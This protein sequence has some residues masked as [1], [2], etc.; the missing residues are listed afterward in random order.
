MFAG[1][2]Q[3]AYKNVIKKA[4]AEINTALAP[5]VI[6]YKGSLAPYKV[7]LKDKSKPYFF[8]LNEEGKIVYSTSG[9]Y[10]T[11]K[12]DRIEDYVSE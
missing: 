8:V 5:Y 9:K 1:V 6:F 2:N 7:H 12:L 10:T 11:K 4:K 3:V